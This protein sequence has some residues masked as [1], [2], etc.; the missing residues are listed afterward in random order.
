M[1][2]FISDALSHSLDH[3]VRL[4]TVFALSA[5]ILCLCWVYSERGGM[6]SSE[7][8]AA[9][10]VFVS[11]PNVLR[12]MLLRTLWASLIGFLLF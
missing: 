8:R 10:G 12:T 4:P 3:V 5:S 7:Y 9:R 11:S 6:P 1:I 2:S